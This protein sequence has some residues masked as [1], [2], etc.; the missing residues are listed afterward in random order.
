[1]FL[2]KK[3]RKRK[4]LAWAWSSPWR[5]WPNYKDSAYIEKEAHQEMPI[6]IWT[7]CI[8]NPDLLQK[9]TKVLS[10]FLSLWH[11]YIWNPVSLSIR[12]PVT[13]LSSPQDR[14]ETVDGADRKG[15]KN[16]V[17]TEGR[18]KV[19]RNF[20]FLLL[21]AKHARALHRGIR[22]QYSS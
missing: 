16:G 21:L 3:E 12:F 4:R 15:G 1:L 19:G 14:A 8:R 6:Q 2:Y 22:V 10:P 20:A 18:K 11:L 13:N 9:T 7:F 17:D 5:S